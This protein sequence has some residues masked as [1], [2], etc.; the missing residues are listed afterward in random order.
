L[1]RTATV[2]MLFLGSSGL[3]GSA[4]LAQ[5]IYFLLIAGLPAIHSFDIGIGGFFLACTAIALG[6]F[7]TDKIGRRTLWLVGV[8]GNVVGM[9]IIGALAYSSSKGA[10][11]GIA[12]VMNLLIS[13]QIATCFNTS[14]TMAP[15]L[16]S[17][18]LRQHTQS[19]GYIVQSLGSWLFQFTVPYMYNVD[20]ANLGAKTGFIFA[21][22]S[23]LLFVI[24]WFMLPETSGLTVED[25]DMA[26]TEKVSP[27]KFADRRTS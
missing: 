3:I 21:G 6:W 14:W 22:L 12:V 1:L 13:W 8:A 20:A 17:Y 27:R 18:R 19:V 25:I 7:M 23:V 10:L 11:W 26:Y 2:A 24:S 9:I 15:E 5:N 16:S 4:F